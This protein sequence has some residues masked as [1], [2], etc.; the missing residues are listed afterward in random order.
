MIRARNS[1]SSACTWACC[2]GLTVT[3][4]AAPSA[5]ASVAAPAPLRASVAAASLQSEP[6]FHPVA[7]EFLSVFGNRTRMIQVALIAV[8]LGIVI[9]VRK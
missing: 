2:F 6:A 8:A 7:A 1:A 5:S 3:I 4:I 9:L